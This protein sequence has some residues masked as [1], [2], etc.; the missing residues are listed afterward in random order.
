[1]GFFGRLF[2]HEEKKVEIDE[3]NKLNTKS[4]ENILKE[5]M[6]ESNKMIEPELK[7][8]HRRLLEMESQLRSSLE[9]LDSAVPKE[10]MDEKLLFAAQTGRPIFKNKMMKVSEA[11]KKSA[12]YDF[13]SFSEYY[14]NCVFS[15]NQANALALTEFRSIGTVFSDEGHAVANILRKLKDSLS[16]MGSR[17]KQH[18]QHVDPYEES[19]DEIVKL[20]GFEEKISDA[21]EREHELK[22]QLEGEE[23]K[24]DEL[25][26]SLAKFLESAEWKGYQ[27]TLDKKKDLGRHEIEIRSGFNEMISSVERPL[28]KA[29]K[30]MSDEEQNVKVFE[31]YM[32]NPFDTF[33]KDDKSLKNLLQQTRKL[34]LEK[35]IDV[36]ENVKDKTM[37]K[38][39]E[40]L[41]KKEFKKIKDEYD[42]TVN[43]IESLNVESPVP[44]ERS[45]IERN[46]LDAEAEITEIKKR[47]EQIGKQIEGAKKEVE[48]VRKEAETKLNELFNNHWELEVNY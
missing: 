12:E 45:V 28:K 19:L 23:K 33:L 42:F 46:I 21:K 32:T 29:I 35:K 8:F 36:N 37:S 9:R 25:K 3:T 13:Q 30:L 34:L 11:L 38:I 24:L 47:D 17:I 39:D 6:T 20:S 5:K 16:D 22:K 14:N 10:K 1:M 4:A 41:E 43:E 26:V 40:W 2:K 44:N 7:G 31:G 15:V 18:K 27:T 48:E